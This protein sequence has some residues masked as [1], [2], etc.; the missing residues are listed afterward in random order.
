VQIA[1]I[2]IFGIAAALILAG[3]A[4][5][6]NS[7]H[8]PA[9]AAIAPPQIDPMSLMANAKNLPSQEELTLKMWG[10]VGPIIGSWTEGNPGCPVRRSSADT[11]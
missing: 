9:Q 3:I 5:W 7:G 8:S 2:S 10:C 6:A 4:T 11:F 1:K